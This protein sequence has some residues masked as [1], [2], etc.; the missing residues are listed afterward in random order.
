MSTTDQ[1]LKQE[2]Q[3]YISDMIIEKDRVFNLV[4]RMDP[5]SEMYWKMFKHYKQLQKKIHTFTA[6]LDTSF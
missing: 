5:K 2:V 4:A 6:D 1:T 3:T